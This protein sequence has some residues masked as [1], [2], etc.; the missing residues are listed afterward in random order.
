M[1][2]LCILSN[3]TFY[4]EGMHLNNTLFLAMNFTLHL[5]SRTLNLKDQ[6]CW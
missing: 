4:F 1:A 5:I 3:N 6:L 2:H